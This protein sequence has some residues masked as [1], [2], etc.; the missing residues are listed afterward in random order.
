M[1][2]RRRVESYRT[3]AGE[4]KVGVSGLVESLTSLVAGGECEPCQQAA[5][6]EQLAERVEETKDDPRWEGIIGFEGVM[7]GDGRYIEP[8][9]LRWGQ[10]PIPLRYVSSDVGAHDGAQVVG[11]IETIE[12]KPVEGDSKAIALWATGTFDSDSEVAQEA[13][14]VV[15]KHTSDG[16]SMDLDDVTFEVRV[17][18]D[19]N[20]EVTTELA[21]ATD[22]E[23]RK[24]VTKLAPTDEVTATTDGRVRAA[25]IVAIPAF[26]DAKIGLVG[27]AVAEN[28]PPGDLDDDEV[29]VEGDV[30]DDEP[31]DDDE[32]AF[33]DEYMAEAVEDDELAGEIESFNW[34]EKVGGLPRYIKRIAKHLKKKM[35]ESHAIATAVNVVKKMCASGDLNY[36]GKQKVNEK[37][38]AE[39]CAAV[40]EW[41]EKKARASAET[42]DFAKEPKA[43]GAPAKEWDPTLHPRGIDGT[44]IEKDETAK[45]EQ[46]LSDVQAA[47]QALGLL[48]GSYANSGTLDEAMKSA[49][50]A[51]QKSVG[52]AETGTLDDDGYSKLTKVSTQPSE[53][54]L[55]E[56]EAD[57]KGSGG[58]GGG[59]S[60]EAKKDAKKSDSDADAR[61]KAVAAAEEKVASVTAAQEA[62]V[63][64][65]QE[66]ATAAELAVEAAEAQAKA[67]QRIAE[68]AADAVARQQSRSDAEQ[69]P[70][71]RMKLEA[72][73]AKAD[74]ARQMYEK[75][76]AGIEAAQEA[77]A[78][79][80][81]AVEAAM[82][83]AAAMVK[84]AED[85]LE[86]AKKGKNG[87]KHAGELTSF[88]L[89][90]SA[91]AEMAAEVETFGY[92]PNQWRNPHNGQWIDMPASFLGD[93]LNWFE[94][95][96]D[97]NYTPKFEE[98][99]DKLKNLHTTMSRRDLNKAESAR[100]YWREADEAAAV[101]DDLI[102][103]LQAEGITGK[104]DVDGNTTLDK[105]K[106]A[107]GDLYVFLE[108]GEDAFALA[109]SDD[110]DNPD[111]IGEWLPPVDAPEI[112]V[113]LQSMLDEA[114]GAESTDPDTMMSIR[115]SLAHGHF[116]DAEA[117]ARADG[118]DDLADAI[119]AESN[120]SVA[121]PG[122]PEGLVKGRDWAK[123]M[124][125]E[126]LMAQ[127]D[128]SQQA[129]DRGD[130]N[131]D[132]AKDEVR[133]LRDEAMVRGL[134]PL[135][136]D[137]S[138]PAGQA[139]VGE[140]LDKMEED[141]LIPNGPETEWGEPV[142]TFFGRL[143]VPGNWV[144]DATPE[145][146]EQ[147]YADYKE[148]K[149]L[150]EA[151]GIPLRAPGII[152]RDL[153]V[154]MGVD[155]IM[156]NLRGMSD[157]T[158]IED[159]EWS[160]SPALIASAIPVAP[161]AAWFENPRLTGPTPLVITE[162]GRVY[163]HVATWD[164]C[165]IGHR[166]RCVQAPRSA[167][168]YAFFR[169]GVIRTAEGTDVPVGQLVLDTVHADTKLGAKATMAHYE[170]TGLAAADVAA[171]DDAYGVWIAGALRPNMTPAKIR[172]LRASP[173]SGDWREIRGQLEMVAALSVNV[174]GF[175]IPR[176][177]GLVASGSLKSLVASGMLAPRKVIKP[178]SPGALSADDLRYLKAL[179]A[180]ERAAHAKSLADRVA[181]VLAEKRK[182]TADALAS[183]F[184]SI[185]GKES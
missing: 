184:R 15:G 183:R 121:V 9:S 160:A 13:M 56:K 65:A 20:D 5:E 63:K 93:F 64:A 27:S 40:A 34:V 146:L 120:R 133:V 153:L 109:I 44:F 25:T 47:L 111:A 35:G 149:A 128:L 73:Q 102:V 142:R 71:E 52:L 30:D 161:P 19:V 89:G 92:N 163:G 18:N 165:H 185:M 28:E 117:A 100:A 132:A 49:I 17:L 127:L 38:R 21:E 61:E 1:K 134:I 167:S 152:V 172:V 6:A 41:E 159:D 76:A 179:A 88:V 164:I 145:L 114:D 31:L 68:A 8:N 150:M 135:P 81:A 62:K 137:V 32:L 103:E 58:G 166:G 178:G 3:A 80:A 98:D 42:E 16:V 156:A 74:A 95:R 75:A 14:R 77:A 124:S 79:A 106:K 78:E 67:L 29:P 177:S 2:V 182:A 169:T 22:E 82:K 37:S 86:K 171:G 180:K 157:G 53:K 91:T 122:T 126:D 136:P 112:S 43:D 94:D 130:G 66:K 129:V 168:G 96:D 181:P 59:G 138:T 11:L 87:G 10:L 90:P 7:T 101:L 60:D 162:D 4:K 116:D 84:A 39:A 147:A 104:P 50:K 23:G 140:M 110:E 46:K 144:R 51:W 55:K 175:P 158:V 154:G 48:D 118:M 174:Q 83:V 113:D 151:E 173:L 69:S 57:A 33:I 155:E 85:A 97:S 143:G 99:L 108:E 45:E 119:E 141:G 131:T 125:D 36:P 123:A 26:A 176:T 148:I 24:V 12:R 115:M 139:A 105:L 170:H 107:A 72:M 54:T 70:E